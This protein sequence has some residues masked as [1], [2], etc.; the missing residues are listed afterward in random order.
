MEQTNR[1]PAKKW[2]TLRNAVKDIRLATEKGIRDFEERAKR[3]GSGIYTCLYN[4]IGYIQG[5][6]MSV[7]DGRTIIIEQN[8]Q[9]YPAKVRYYYAQRAPRSVYEELGQHIQPHV[10]NYETDLAQYSYEKIVEGNYAGSFIISY[11]KRGISMMML[12]PTLEEM[13]QRSWLEKKYGVVWQLREELRQHHKQRALY[14]SYSNEEF[15][16]FDGWKFHA[17]TKQQAYHICLKHID[18]VCNRWNKHTPGDKFIPKNK[19]IK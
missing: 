2:P 5:D 9:F 19:L 13:T 18:D 12:K 8:L 3:A 16:H 10:P 6:S 1:I 7:K 11:S 14:F 4:E 17:C 15:L